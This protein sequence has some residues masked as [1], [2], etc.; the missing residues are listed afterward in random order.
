MVS[1]HAFE[2]IL[3]QR[4]EALL[5]LDRVRKLLETDPTRDVTPQKLRD[6]LEEPL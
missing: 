6:A 3:N 1:N 2:A 5:I 4:D